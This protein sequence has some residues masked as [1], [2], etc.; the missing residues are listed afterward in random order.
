MKVSFRKDDIKIGDK[1]LNLA[2][3]LMVQG[4][5]RNTGDASG[6][7]PSPFSMDKEEL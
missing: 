7:K 6:L 5:Q 2:V 4:F 3:E 1:H